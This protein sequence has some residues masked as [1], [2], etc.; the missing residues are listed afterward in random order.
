MEHGE[1]SVTSHDCVSHY[2]PPL[3]V[4]AAL[5]KFLSFQHHK[6]QHYRDTATS[7]TEQPSSESKCEGKYVYYVQQIQY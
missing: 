2:M 1:G 5:R 7:V 6:L 4:A 3:H